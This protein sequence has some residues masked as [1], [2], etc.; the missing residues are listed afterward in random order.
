[1]RNSDRKD[2]QF[3][4]DVDRFG[5]RQLLRPLSPGEIGSMKWNT[6][7]YLADWEGEGARE[8]DGAFW[9]LP[10]WMGRYYG[11]GKGK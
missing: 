8:M 5:K 2:V 7:P 4:P 1:M 11:V 10:Y 6:N 9:L 3:M